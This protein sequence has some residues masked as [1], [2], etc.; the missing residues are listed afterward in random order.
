MKP[1]DRLFTRLV[2]DTLSAILA[3]LALTG[4]G[5]PTRNLPAQ[6]IGP[7]IGYHWSEERVLNSQ[8][9]VVVTISGG[10]TRAAALGASVLQGMEQIKAEDGQSLTQKIDIVSSVSGGSV[11]AAAFA[12]AGERGLDNFREDFLEKDGMAAILLAGLNPVGLARLSTEGTERIDLLINYFD[13]TLYH[14]KTYADVVARK[15]APLLLLNAA[16]MVS[17]YPFSFTQSNFDLI[18]SDLTKLKLSTAVAASA[19]FPVAL[20]AVSLTNYS[21]CAAQGGDWPPT[22]VT[23]GAA[24]KWV[25]NPERVS[26]GR[27]RLQ[28]AQGATAHPSSKYIHLLDGGVADNLGVTEPIDILTRNAPYPGLLNQFSSGSIREVIFVMINA[29]SF[30]ASSLDQQH[31]PPTIGEMLS[32]TI[33]GALDNATAG[34][35]SKLRTVLFE[36]FSVQADQLHALGDLD[37]EANLRNMSQHVHLIQVDF[38]AIENANCRDAFHHISTSWSLPKSDVDGLLQIGRALMFSSPELPAVLKAIN[39]HLEGATPT[40]DDVC[41]SFRRSH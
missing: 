16:D 22:Y 15:G 25:D 8:T 3:A 18:C 23:N 2:K 27:I 9:L 10:G 35:A 40:T 37:G 30:A 24:S 14:D 31:A 5:Y 29:K 19:A 11:P 21:P 13:K 36:K 41:K 33:N 1:L 32:A 34:G 26:L 38:D 4:C 39:G 6:S 28:Y 7:N 20:S 12:L 17:E